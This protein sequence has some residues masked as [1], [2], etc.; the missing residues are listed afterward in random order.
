[1]PPS[2]GDVPETPR[3][4][5]ALWVLGLVV[6]AFLGIRYLGRGTDAAPAA[7]PAIQVGEGGGGESSRVTVH[8]AGAV[9][10]VLVALST[11][12]PPSAGG[13]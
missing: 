13:R 11:H 10:H 4:I 5:I 6:V 1:M 7:A 9:R 12:L 8:V 3:H 2:V